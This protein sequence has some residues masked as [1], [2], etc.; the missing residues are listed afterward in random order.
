MDIKHHHAATVPMQT[1]H[2]TVLNTDNS[3]DNR[4]V[5]SHSRPTVLIHNMEV[6]RRT[7]YSLLYR[8]THT[9]NITR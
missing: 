5:I 3:T 4:M 7:A 6:N 1:S 9:I 2:L 8:S